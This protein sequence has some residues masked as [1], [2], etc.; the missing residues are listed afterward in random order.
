M[1][2]ERLAISAAQL[3]DSLLLL[4]QHIPHGVILSTCNRTEIYV[5]GR[6]ATKYILDICNWLDTKIKE[7]IFCNEDISIFLKVGKLYIISFV[8]SPVWI[9]K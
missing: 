5:S 2:R 7:K 8:S 4:R 6:K 3:H 1:L 9:L